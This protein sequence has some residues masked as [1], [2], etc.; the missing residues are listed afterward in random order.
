[1]PIGEAQIYFD[2]EDQ[3]SVI[4]VFVKD[5]DK[6]DDLGPAMQQA[7]GQSVALSDWRFRNSTVFGALEM[8][9]NM[10]FIIL[11][12]IVIV[13][14]MIAPVP[15]PTRARQAISIVMLWARPHS[16]EPTRKTLMPQI[17]TGLRP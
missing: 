7:A 8:E 3:I 2:M 17:R 10:M 16:A 15:R 9:R 1:M 12:M 11:T 5:A 13:A 6:V 4:E 14:G